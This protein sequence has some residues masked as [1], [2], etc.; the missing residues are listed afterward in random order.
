MEETH[1]SV[2]RHGLKLSPSTAQTASRRWYC[3]KAKCAEIHRNL[4]TNSGSFQS[5]NLVIPGGSTS[6]GIKTAPSL[7]RK[8]I[9][10]TT[11]LRIRQDFCMILRDSGPGWARNSTTAA[12][13]SRVQ[14]RSYLSGFGDIRSERWEYLP[15]YASTLKTTQESLVLPAH[16]STTRR[17]PDPAQRS[18]MENKSVS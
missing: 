11:T 10:R 4:A 7:P 12:D 6:H 17:A 9:A 13:F 5:S 14:S 2:A 15:R 16:I 18:E 3:T 8:R 1:R